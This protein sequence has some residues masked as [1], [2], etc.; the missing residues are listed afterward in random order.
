MEIEQRRS[1]RYSTNGTVVLPK[2]K[3]VVCDYSID[4]I[5]FITDQVLSIG[6]NVD[7]TVQLEKPGI[8][9]EIS[10]G[11]CANVV[12][13]Q[14]DADLTGVAVAITKMWLKSI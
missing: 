13:V 5:Y 11:C 8:D 2:G 14:K 1:V 10:L 6:D 7:L 12:R 3:G 9:K 4:G